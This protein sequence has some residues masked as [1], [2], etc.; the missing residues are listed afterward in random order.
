MLPVRTLT[1][2]STSRH[3][4]EHTAPT[5]KLPH[6]R[7]SKTPPLFVICAPLNS[8]NPS[9]NLRLPCKSRSPFP[10]TFSPS[11]D[12]A[13][14]PGRQTGSVEWRAARGELGGGRNQHQRHPPWK[15]NAPPETSTWGRS[16]LSDRRHLGG[17]ASGNSRLS[18]GA[19]A[20]DVM[21]SK[22]TLV[23]QSVE[24]V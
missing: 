7:L 24:R 10:L 4:A 16:G 14:L 3:C 11:Q 15:E 22:L 6:P 19:P 13:N 9:S 1:A 17:S 23:M 2:M 12:T 8:N 18:G 20:N 21:W 5:L